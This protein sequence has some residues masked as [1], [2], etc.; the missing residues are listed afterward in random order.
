MLPSRPCFPLARMPSCTTSELRGS[1]ASR[2]DE[3]TTA[4]LLVTRTHGGRVSYRKTNGTVMC[5][6]GYPHY[7]V[8]TVPNRRSADTR[9]C[10]Y[11][12]TPH[13]FAVAATAAAFAACPLLGAGVACTAPCAWACC[14]TGGTRCPSCGHSRWTTVTC[15]CTAT[16]WGEFLLEPTTLTLNQRSANTCR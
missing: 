12:G 6:A 1:H 15:P 2:A 5:V 10:L 16:K 11:P 7:C 14:R 4:L 8:S 13:A 9:V 3:H